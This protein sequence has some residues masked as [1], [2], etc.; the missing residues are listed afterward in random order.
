MCCMGALNPKKCPTSPCSVSQPLETMTAPIIPLCLFCCPSPTLLFSISFW[1]SYVPYV[2]L[3]QVQNWSFQSW[4]AAH[5]RA[6]ARR[7]AHDYCA[8]RPPS[9]SV[10]QQHSSLLANALLSRSIHW[11]NNG[12]LCRY[13][14][15]ITN[16]EKHLQKFPSFS[17]FSN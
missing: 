16:N 9:Q 5:V 14:V 4:M 11:N 2:T 7:P 6:A 17:E 8:S 12:N 13:F 10:G 1:W 3:L 15:C